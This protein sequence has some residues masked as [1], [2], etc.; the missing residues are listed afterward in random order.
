[1]GPN[2]ST[3]TTSPGSIGNCRRHGEKG[4]SKTTKP[5]KMPTTKGY[6]MA[7]QPRC[8]IIKVDM[9]LAIKPATPK[10]ATRGTATVE[11]WVIAVDMTRITTVATTTG[12]RVPLAQKDK[13]TTVDGYNVTSF[14]SKTQDVTSEI[15]DIQVRPRGS[16]GHRAA[17]GSHGLKPRPARRR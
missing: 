14:T 17:G 1:M 7:S 10:V 9:D 16:V 2:T 11:G 15:Q 5:N 13:H 3:N 12:A 4:C 6:S 8:N